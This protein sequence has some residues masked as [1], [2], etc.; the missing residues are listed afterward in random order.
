MIDDIYHILTE[1]R[2]NFTVQFLSSHRE[3]GES[4]RIEVPLKDRNLADLAHLQESI[5]DKQHVVA[6]LDASSNSV[7]IIVNHVDS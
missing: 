5:K 1:L 4:A 2:F 6:M 3:H 7:V